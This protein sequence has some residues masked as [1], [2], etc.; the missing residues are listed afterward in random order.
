MFLI[1]DAHDVGQIA[2]GIVAHVAAVDQHPALFQ[3]VAAV[4]AVE[5]G[6]LAAAVGPQQAETLPFRYVQIY[7]L[8][9]VIAAV[10]AEAG[11]L[12]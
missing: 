9:H 1:D 12:N 5:E 8:P 11:V 10:V 2:D 4:N 3:A 6:G 7:M